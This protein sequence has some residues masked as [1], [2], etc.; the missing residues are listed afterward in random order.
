MSKAVRKVEEAIS[1]RS[2]KYYLY[3]VHKISVSSRTVR[4]WITTGL[5]DGF[6]L[7]AI[8]KFSW[9]TTCAAIDAAVQAGRIPPRRGNPN[10]TKKKAP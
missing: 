9:L 6:H 5:I 8:S 4:R 7:E 3:S 10:W 2:A 1:M